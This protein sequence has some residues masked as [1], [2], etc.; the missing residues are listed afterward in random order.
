MRTRRVDSAWNTNGHSP[1]IQHL[2]GNC[3]QRRLIAF[4]SPPKYQTIGFDFIPP[5]F[6]TDDKEINSGGGNEDDRFVGSEIDNG[7]ERSTPV[8]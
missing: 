6:Q 7:S 1:T 4:H 3:L 2:S 5:H 8:E